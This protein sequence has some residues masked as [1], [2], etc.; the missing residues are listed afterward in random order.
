M[1]PQVSKLQLQCLVCAHARE[2]ERQRDRQSKQE[3]NL[4]CFLLFLELYKHRDIDLTSIPAGNPFFC[5]VCL[6]HWFPDFKSYTCQASSR[7]KGSKLVLRLAEPRE[8]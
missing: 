7:H 2:K 4:P 5:A 1:D 3:G 6:S 8:G